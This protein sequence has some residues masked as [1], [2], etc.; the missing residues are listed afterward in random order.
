L[1][2]DLPARVLKIEK[3]E[4]EGANQYNNNNPK[5]DDVPFHSSSFDR[6]KSKLLFIPYLS[7][8]INI[9]ARAKKKRA[10][11]SLMVDALL[12]RKNESCSEVTP[13]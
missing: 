9:P 11:K 6:G 1:R 2:E 12:W 8:K 13:Q 10:V 5:D 3:V 4:A 7:A